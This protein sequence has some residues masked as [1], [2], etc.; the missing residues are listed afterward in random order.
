MI[1]H[2]IYLL[3]WSLVGDSNPRRMILEITA[4]ATELTKQ[5]YGMAVLDFGNLVKPLLLFRVVS[6]SVF[7]LPYLQFG[8]DP[9]S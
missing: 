3:F 7:C 4:L 8:G 9:I 6:L 5:N 1:A 2:T